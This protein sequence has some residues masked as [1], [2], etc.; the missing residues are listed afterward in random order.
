MHLVSSGPLREKK[1]DIMR[2][3]KLIKRVMKHTRHSW[4]HLIIPLL[5]A[6]IVRRNS[7]SLKARHSDK[8]QNLTSLL[9]FSYSYSPTKST[10]SQEAFQ[11]QN[12]E[13]SSKNRLIYGPV[14]LT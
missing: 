1:R 13:K 14:P 6:K 3:P 10:P 12:S 9:Y 8:E 2:S 4:S 5:W 7:I 11:K